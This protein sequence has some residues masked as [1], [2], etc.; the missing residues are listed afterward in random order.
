MKFIKIFY[1]L[2]AFVLIFSSC[3][4]DI[5]SIGLGLVSENLGNSFSDTTQLVAYTLRND[6]I[7]TTNVINCI[8]GSLSDPIFGKISA[9]FYAKYSLIGESVYFGDHPILDSVVLVVQYSGYYGDTTSLL[10]MS[11]FEL[12]ELLDDKTIYY[13]SDVTE[14]L[15]DNLLYNP[16]ESFSPRPTTMIRAEGDSVIRPAHLRIRL[17]DELGNK[18][19]EAERNGQ[20]NNATSFQNFFKGLYFTI[21]SLSSTGCLV[22]FNMRGAISAINLYYHQ[23][24]STSNTSAR[25]MFNTPSSTTCYTHIDFDYEGS[26]DFAFKDQVVYG[27]KERGK[28]QLY[29]QPLGGLK[30]YIDFPHLR[31]TFKGKNIVINK[32]ELVINDINGSS[33]FMAPPTLNLQM[34]KSDGSVV[35]VPDA[36]IGAGYFGGTYNNDT[37]SYRFRITKFI[38]DYINQDS[39]V[40][41]HV[42]NDRKQGLYL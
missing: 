7:A 25:Y 20:L 8:A 32:A 10:R 23:A 17:S 40:G 22:Y 9:G 4:K 13:S 42:F 24:G 41:H 11:V 12:T 15:N 29:V 35:Y 36:G 3:K 26:S 39:P 34:I 38:Q 19:I 16:N 31:E 30:T 28:E 33:V 18:I 21:E 6:S 2:I 37:K 27:N 14:H 5:D 1:F